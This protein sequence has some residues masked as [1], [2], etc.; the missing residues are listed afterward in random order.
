[1]CR[2]VVGVLTFL[3]LFLKG[4]IVYAAQYEIKVRQVNP[5]KWTY[6]TICDDTQLC[7]IFMGIVP[8]NHTFNTDDLELDIGIFFKNKNA[9]FQFKS[10]SQYFFAGTARKNS[11]VFT[12]QPD[13]TNR[14]EIYKRDQAAAEDPEN[15]LYKLPVIRPL[16]KRVA[17]LE[18]SVFTVVSDQ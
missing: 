16:P 9:Y 12:G 14:I 18:I 3:W 7:H 1:M 11:P 17:E 6:N 10:G 2:Y 4:H 8:Q 15:D 5:D 13:E